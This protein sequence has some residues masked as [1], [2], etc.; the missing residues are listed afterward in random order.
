MA[1]AADHKL[2]AGGAQA[3]VPTLARPVML[4]QAGTQG[5]GQTDTDV[6]FEAR[7][8]AT[9]ERPGYLLVR[10]RLS[11]LTASLVRHNLTPDTRALLEENAMSR[12]R[13]SHGA[14][15]QIVAE[16]IHAVHDGMKLMGYHELRGTSPPLPLPA[17]SGATAAAVQLYLR[18][19]D[20]TAP[21]LTVDAPDGNLP[22]VLRACLGVKHALLRLSPIAPLPRGAASHFPAK[23]QRFLERAALAG[24]HDPSRLSDAALLDASCVARVSLRLLQEVAA[25]DAWESVPF[26]YDALCAPH[27]EPQCSAVG[28]SEMGNALT[29][30]YSCIEELLFDAFHLGGFNAQSATGIEAVFTLSKSFAW[31]GASMGTELR[32][33]LSKTSKCFFRDKVQ[34]RIKNLLGSRTHQQHKS[35]ATTT[36]T[37]AWAMYSLSTCELPVTFDCHDV[38]GQDVLTLAPLVHDGALYLLVVDLGSL[39]KFRQS[40]LFEGR[41]SRPFASVS[42]SSERGV[43]VESLD[44]VSAFALRTDASVIGDH[45]WISH[46][47]LETIARCRTAEAPA[48]ED[49]ERIYRRFLSDAKDSAAREAQGRRLVEMC[50]AEI[51]LLACHRKFKGKLQQ[52]DP[53]LSF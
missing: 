47:A 12:W 11:A 19:S 2:C 28:V 26:C 31:C 8:K 27:A 41:V 37:T 53:L 7:N 48:T 4:D 33:R 34:D 18:A 38:R 36:T 16:R 52:R 49:T 24:A 30:K 3:W 32:T 44:S 5:D 50:L 46:C 10:K 39:A 14:Q 42:I 9:A 29:T 20:T 15:A 40:V 45:S 35:P 1:S 17:V 51:T 22:C 21:V 43:C 25:P 6:H 23:E 13:K